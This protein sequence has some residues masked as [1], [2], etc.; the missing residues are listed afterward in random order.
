M[1][2]W[3]YLEAVKLKLLLQE[4]W[5]LITKDDWSDALFFEFYHDLVF[6]GISYE[7]VVQLLDSPSFY[8]R[9]QNHPSSYTLLDALKMELSQQN[10]IYASYWSSKKE[11]IQRDG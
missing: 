3:G 5:R 11:T 6:L 7:K 9:H 10:P 2:D 1:G 4:K 8:K